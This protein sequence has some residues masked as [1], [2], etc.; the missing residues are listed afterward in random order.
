MNLKLCLTQT[1]HE[2]TEKE[3]DK[4]FD[5]LSRKNYW[6]RSRITFQETQR[7]SQKISGQDHSRVRQHGTS[8]AERRN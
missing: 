3:T 1:D 4:T 6:C 8:E 7:C 5:G 2:L